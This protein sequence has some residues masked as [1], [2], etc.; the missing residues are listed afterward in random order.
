MPQK[1]L[2]SI[3]SLLPSPITPSLAAVQSRLGLAFNLNLDSLQT[4]RANIAAHYD[5]SNAMFEAFL[6][7][8]MTYSCAIFEG[9]DEDLQSTGSGKATE[10]IID[11]RKND[12]VDSL[13]TP[14][15]TP[16]SASR[17]PSD[18]I[19]THLN[20][21]LQSEA[22]FPFLKLQPGHDDLHA[23]QLRK[24]AH[25]I[26]Q[27]RLPLPPV[28][29]SDVDPGFNSRDA[30][31]IRVLEIGTGWGSL[32]LTLAT[33][34]PNVHV[35]TLTLSA[36]QAAHVRSLIAAHAMQHGDSTLEE[37]IRIHEVSYAALPKLFPEWRQRFDR[38]VSVE[39]V[40]AVGR[41]K[42]ALEGYWNVID[43]ALKEKEG[44]G[45]VM[46]ITIPEGRGYRILPFPIFNPN[47]TPGYE[48][49]LHEIDFIQKWVR[50]AS[51]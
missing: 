29:T 35:D 23:A 30:R 42:G 19:E 37:R 40:E 2:S 44:L 32:C 12:G 22:S 14:I 24:L 26:G 7:P 17:S 46:G 45:V 27:L 10:S 11:E 38:V 48:R 5:L 1:I 21:Q 51:F 43:W 9:L 4:A 8:D 15:A 47:K 18:S 25:I 36:L 50:T 13:P 34:Y 16:V 28:P 20:T 31:T 33:R 39:M 3:S 41:K 6:S 49:Y